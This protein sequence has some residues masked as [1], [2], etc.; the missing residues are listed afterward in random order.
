MPLDISEE[1]IGELKNILAKE[2]YE[3]NT[4]LSMGNTVE[5]FKNIEVF[6][7]QPDAV[8]FV[9]ERSFGDYLKAFLISIA[10]AWIAWTA[11][12]RTNVLEMAIKTVKKNKY[13]IAQFAVFS[14]VAVLAA[15]MIEMVLG[16]ILSGA[17]F[18]KYR[19]VFI[20]GIA[21]LVCVFIFTRKNLA[22]ARK[23]YVKQ[24]FNK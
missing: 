18:N 12:T 5:G 2:G 20:A 6:D 8:P 22:E 3:I 16:L 9:P 21:E 1:N 19:C 10:I 24:N 4:V 15:V 14:V 23:T 13:K 17:G 11:E 7:K